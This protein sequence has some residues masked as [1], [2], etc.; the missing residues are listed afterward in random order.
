MTI[1]I[2]EEICNNND[3]T[4]SEALVLLAIKSGN[5]QETIDSLLKTEA[6]ILD[7]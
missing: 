1:T 3:L 2:N 7:I 4:F 6:I 5:L